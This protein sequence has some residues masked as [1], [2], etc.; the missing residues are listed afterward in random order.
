MA[1]TFSGVSPLTA[2]PDYRIAG[3]NWN[4]SNRQ[5]IHIDAERKQM[6]GNKAE[7]PSQAAFNPA[8]VDRD[9]ETSP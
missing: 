4:I 5:T 2:V 6:A 7:P 3:G 1:A 8:A 9:R